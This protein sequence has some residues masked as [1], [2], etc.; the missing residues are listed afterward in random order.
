MLPL[1]MPCTYAW[2]AT[3][4]Q[5][6]HASLLLITYTQVTFALI[7]A[8]DS[9]AICSTVTV[10]LSTALKSQSQI[11]ARPPGTPHLR[12]YTL[13]LHL[14]PLPSPLQTTVVM[15]VTCVLLLT[16]VWWECARAVSQTVPLER[17]V[18]TVSAAT[19]RECVSSQ[20]RPQCVR[21]LALVLVGCACSRTV[22]ATLSV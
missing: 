4:R 3:V 20:T 1:R 9:P 21:V 17:H 8:Q 16:C 11:S 6:P 2:H 18:L 15:M 13:S 5:I 14:H 12:P 19:A 7:P 22:R 10:P